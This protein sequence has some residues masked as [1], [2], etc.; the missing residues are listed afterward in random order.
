MVPSTDPFSSFGQGEAWVAYNWL[1]EVMIYQLHQ[2]FGLW[3][4]LLY[5]VVLSF[6][7]VVAVHRLVAKREPRFLVATGLVGLALFPMGR[8]LVERTWLFTILFFTLTL[9]V[10]LVLRAGRRTPL[11]WLL[12]FLYV[13]WANVHIQFIYGLLIL[14]LACICPIFDKSTGWRRCLE[15]ASCAGSRAWWR[16]MGLTLACLLATLVTPYHFRLYAVV[17]D[18]ATQTGVNNVIGELLPADFRSPGDWAL[19]G[20]V[21]AAAFCLGTQT[22]TWSLE[23]RRAS[24]HRRSLLLVPDMSRCLVRCASLAHDFDHQ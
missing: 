15:H 16:L 11:I 18:L 5:R 8:L 4:V 2:A 1:F 6:A 14:G 12:P 21:L 20:L 3:G 23:L 17:I 22:Q 7:I 9:E 19:L 24:A 13:L 10:I